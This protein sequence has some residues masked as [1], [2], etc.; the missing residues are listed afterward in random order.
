MFQRVDKKVKELFAHVPKELRLK[1]VELNRAE[2]GVHN[3]IEFIA[4]GR[5]TASP[6]RSPWSRRKR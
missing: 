1:K 5:A 6:T 2:T 3:F 4:E